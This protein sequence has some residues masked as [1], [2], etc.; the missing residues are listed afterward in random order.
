MTPHGPAKA[1]PLSIVSSVVLMGAFS[2]D[3]CGYLSLGFLEQTVHWAGGKNTSEILE[4]GGIYIA[5]EPPALSGGSF[6]DVPPAISA[7]T[8][9]AYACFQINAHRAAVLLARSVIE[10]TAKEK[11]ITSGT[12]VQ[13]IDRLHA[14]DHIREH[15]KDAAHEIRHLG[16]DM[17]HGDFINDVEPEEANEILGL[18]S[19]VLQEVFQSPA[20]VAR[21]QQER[22]AK[23]QAAS[24]GS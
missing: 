13:K 1:V 22:L 16:N 5:W 17:A 23:K 15:I 6:P 18:M 8:Q 12:L 3:E 10:A 7:A 14:D 21:R 4:A 19:E 2:C 9:E 11:G 20:R 24:S